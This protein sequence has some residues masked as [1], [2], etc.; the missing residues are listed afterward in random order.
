MD[1]APV[2]YLA[3]IGPTQFRGE[4]G[5][6]NRVINVRNPSFHNYRLEIRPRNHDIGYI[7]V[8]N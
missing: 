2:L 4:I 5:A 3:S 6:L 7:P 8:V 1:P